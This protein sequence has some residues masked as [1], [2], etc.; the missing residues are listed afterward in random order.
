MTD[1]EILP[2]DDKTIEILNEFQQEIMQIRGRME[3]ALRLFMRYHD[4]Q[5]AWD[6][7]PNNREL[8]KRSENPDRVVNSTSGSSNAKESQ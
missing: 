3:G 1:K 7:A 4:L 2:L 5:G 8:I 6:V